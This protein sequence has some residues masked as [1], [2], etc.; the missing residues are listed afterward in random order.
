M[1]DKTS[2]D[3]ILKR[4]LSIR[5]KK[6]FRYVRKYFLTGILVTAPIAITLYLAYVFIVFMDHQVAKLWPGEIEPGGSL[7]PGSGI[8]ITLIFFVAVGGRVPSYLGSSF[9][10][11]AVVIAATSYSG[12]GPNAN[13]GVAL[14]G[15]I[16][17]GVALLATTFGTGAFR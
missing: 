11:I 7:F 9:S 4:H 10:F 3:N 12:S 13:V 6:V 1:Q 15:I 2:I 8:I 17:A 5:S 14:T 16:A